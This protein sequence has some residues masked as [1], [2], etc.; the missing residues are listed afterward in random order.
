MTTTEQFGDLTV[1]FEGADGHVIA[2]TDDAMDLIGNASYSGVGLVALPVA[3][4]HPDFFILSSLLAG[5][6][7]QKFVN[8]RVRVAIVG[9]ISAYVAGSDALRDFVWESNRGEHVWFV[10]D[11]DELRARLT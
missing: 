5:D 4:L 1:Q 8:Y 3:R 10:A 11:R 6:I 9:D 2:R 7:L